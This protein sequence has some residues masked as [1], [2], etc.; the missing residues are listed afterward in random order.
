MPRSTST[1]RW[2]PCGRQPT[3]PDTPSKGRGRDGKGTAQGLPFESIK[4]ECAWLR[5]VHDTGGVDQSE[6]QWRDALRVSMF[7][8]NGEALIHEFSCKHEGYDSEA[9]K[10]KYTEAYKAKVEKDLG[11]PQCRTIHDHH[12]DPAASPRAT[13]PHL[14]LGKSPLNLVRLDAG[15][16]RE[17]FFA[18]MV[19]HTYMFAPSR[20]LWPGTSVDARIRPIPLTDDAGV[21]LFD[22]KGKPK[23]IPASLW[24]D[25]NQPV[26]M[27]TWAPGLP[28][29]I[30]DRLIA[31]GGWI[32]RKGGGARELL[33]HVS[34][35][36]D[37][38]GFLLVGLAAISRSAATGGAYV[39][40]TPRVL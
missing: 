24:L 25:K 37:V 18:Y 1:R 7:L 14:K 19:T 33:N 28:M 12:D 29:I 4:A 26:E 3:L 2:R 21:P 35:V 40:D 20:E 9:T 5:H 10:K 22:E 23:T 34:D 27:M 6:V 8:Q 11:Y 32:P 36:S 17:D 31:E 30:A 38:S 15:V 16:R 39:L 13:C